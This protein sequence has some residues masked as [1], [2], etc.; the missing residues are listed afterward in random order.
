MK[1]LEDQIQKLQSQVVGSNHPQG[2]YA[3]QVSNEMNQIMSIHANML[4]NSSP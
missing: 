2:S 4:N 3:N 1:E